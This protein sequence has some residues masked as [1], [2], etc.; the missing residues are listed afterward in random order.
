MEIVNYGDQP[1]LV[2]TLEKDF[3]FIDI[4]NFD[5]DIY[6]FISTRDGI[7]KVNDEEITIPLKD[8]IIGYVLKTYDDKVLIMNPYHNDDKLKIIF[9]KLMALKSYDKPDKVLRNKKSSQELVYRKRNK[10]F[11]RSK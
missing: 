9:D 10:K 11:K 2:A 8:F 4:C 7:K 1:I 3:Q 5:E 6:N